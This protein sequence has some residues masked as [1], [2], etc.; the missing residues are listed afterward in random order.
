[1]RSL[2]GAHRD[3]ERSLARRRLGICWPATSSGAGQ[4]GEL[5]PKSV[6][7]YE[8]TIDAVRSRL[9]DIRVSEAT[10]GCSMRS[11]A[12]SAATTARPENVTPRWR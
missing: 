12:A 4:D 10:P 5:A 11:C 1:M 3:R 2:R 6:D 9:A 7:T 8:A